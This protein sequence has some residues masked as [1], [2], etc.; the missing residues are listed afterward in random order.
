MAVD[1]RTLFLEFYL[2]SS[3]YSNSETCWVVVDAGADLGV[4]FQ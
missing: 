4:Y 2:E 3:G 1:V